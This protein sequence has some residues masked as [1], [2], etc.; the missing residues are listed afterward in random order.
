MRILKIKQVAEQ[1][2]LAPRTIYRLI[3][4]GQFPKSVQLSPRRVGWTAD[5][6]E[7]WLSGIIARAAA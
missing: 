7:K 2:G 1:T 4:A 5:Q 6:I 3:S